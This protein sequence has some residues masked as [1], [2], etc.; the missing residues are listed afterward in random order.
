MWDVRCIVADK[1]SVL[2]SVVSYKTNVFVRN[3]NVMFKKFMKFI[4]TTYLP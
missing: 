3:S 2:E 1:K 4:A